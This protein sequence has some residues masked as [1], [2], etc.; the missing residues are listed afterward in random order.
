[1]ATLKFYTYRKTLTTN[2]ALCY[3][4]YVRSICLESTEPK[5]SL[6]IF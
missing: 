2:G 3:E 5:Q 4:T 1:M 6:L